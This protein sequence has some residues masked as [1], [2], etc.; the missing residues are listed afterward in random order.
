MARKNKQTD[1]GQVII[2]K[3]HP[4]PPLPH[5]IETAQILARHYK[6]AVQFLIPVDDFKRPTAD[7]VMNGVG[8]ELKCPEGSSKF[9]IQHQFRR[10]SKQ[11]KNIIIDTRRTKLDYETIVNRVQHEL[12]K[13]PYIRKIILID[14]SEKIVELK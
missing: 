12:L 3:N 9:T 7:I 6:T 5:E 8:W 10:A 4:N 13:R 2:P 14:K 11:S 1:S